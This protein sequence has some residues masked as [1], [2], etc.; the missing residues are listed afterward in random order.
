MTDRERLLAIMA[1]KS[2]D[3]VPWIPRLSIWYTARRRAGTLP[4]PYRDMSLTE[5]EQDLRLGTPARD[6]VIFRTQMKNVEIDKRRLNDLEERTEY[7]TPVGT[8]ST[9][10]RGSDSL[11]QKGI[12]DLEVEFM[13]KRREDYTVVQYILENTEVLPAYED[14][15]Q[16]EDEIGERGYPMV[17]CGDCPFHH[18][19]RALA[20]YENAYFHLHDFPAEVEQLLTVMTQRD[21]EIVWKTI[22]ESPAKLILHGVHYSSQMTPPSLFTEYITP[23]YQELSALLRAHGQTL[24]LHGDNDTRHILTHI[25][26]AGFGM[27]ECF[28]THPLVETTLGEARR[29]WG[30][31]VIIWGGVPSVILED[32]YSDEQFE[33]YMQEVFQT[34]APGDAF[35]LGV[36]DNVMPEAK[37]DRIRRITEMVEQHGAY[38]IKADATLA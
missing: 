36:A 5:V 10:F 24:T 17:H 38:P 7:R 14:Y 27:V 4:G 32:P 15:A 37:I 25:E 20:G 22:T 30:N 8:V 29:A 33:A 28:A 11:R 35:I 26:Q 31:R 19:M 2:P 16:Y 21:R 1:G 18:W 6:G 9:L 13:L 23:Y 34:I 3:R 12:Q